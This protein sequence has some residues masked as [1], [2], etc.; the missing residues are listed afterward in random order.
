M[1]IKEEV[2][3][4]AQKAIFIFPLH[5]GNEIRIDGEQFYVLVN[6]T[7]GFID[8]L[9]APKVSLDLIKQF[10]SNLICPIEHLSNDFKE[11]D[12]NLR[13][14]KEY[15]KEGL[16]EQLKYEICHRESKKKLAGVNAYTGEAIC[17]K[18]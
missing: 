9:M 14:S 12:A 15:D 13:W 5:N 8:L 6:R 16:Y 17:F 18:I 4:E 3:N 11:I 10:Q 1:E 7:T 2:F